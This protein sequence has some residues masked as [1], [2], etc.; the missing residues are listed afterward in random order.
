MKSITTNSDESV[1]RYRGDVFTG[2]N[3]DAVNSM[4]SKGITVG[5][6]MVQNGCC[7]AFQM[8]RLINA[9]TPS[10]QLNVEDDKGDHQHQDG[11]GSSGLWG[12][13]VVALGGVNM[14]HPLV[15]SAKETHHGAAGPDHEANKH[16]IRT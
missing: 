9:F 13:V 10:T 11:V 16:G 12:E 8:Y 1:K 15:M 14:L 2:E 3:P 5:E 6:V 4:S 7:G